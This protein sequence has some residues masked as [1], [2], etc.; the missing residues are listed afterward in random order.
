MLAAGGVSQQDELCSRNSLYSRSSPAAAGVYI[1]AQEPCS[2]RSLAAA[3]RRLEPGGQFGLHNGA[4]RTIL[5][6]SVVAP[7]PA[8]VATSRAKV[9]EVK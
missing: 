6:R 3:C 1:T 4:V 9:S 5:T 7:V 2:R 8:I